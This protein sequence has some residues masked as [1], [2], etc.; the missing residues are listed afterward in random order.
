MNLL[1][2]INTVF[3]LIVHSYNAKVS[4]K[5]CA[6]LITDNYTMDDTSTREILAECMLIA[7]DLH[8]GY[9]REYGR[10]GDKVVKQVLD[11]I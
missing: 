6:Q 4:P 10:Y 3:D 7:R 11:L 9:N 1:N 5:A 2:P 8:N